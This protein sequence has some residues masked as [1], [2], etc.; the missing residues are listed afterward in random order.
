M[1][2]IIMKNKETKKV[3]YTNHLNKEIAKEYFEKWYSKDWKIMMVIEGER[4]NL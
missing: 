1:V 2:T 4:I 3:D